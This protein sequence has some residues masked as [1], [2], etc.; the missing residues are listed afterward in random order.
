[1]L[2]NTILGRILSL[3]YLHTGAKRT[4]LH[5]DIKPQ[6]I[7]LDNKMVPKLAQL[8]ISLQENYFKSKA[9]PTLLDTNQLLDIIFD[10]LSCWITQISYAILVEI[11]AVYP[12]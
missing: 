7:L 2:L 4:I 11:V 9:T 1:M 3:H 5:C 6:T 10:S 12:Y 8:G